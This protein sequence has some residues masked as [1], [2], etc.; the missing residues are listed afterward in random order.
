MQYHYM[1]KDQIHNFYYPMRP[2][3]M[4]DSR[5]FCSLKIR[6]YAIWSWLCCFLCKILIG[7][8][9]GGVITERCYGCGRCSPVCPY[10]KISKF[11]FFFCFVSL[12]YTLNSRSVTLTE[13]KWVLQ[14]CAIWLRYGHI[15]KGRYCHCSTSWTRRRRC[16]RDTY[17][18]KV[19]VS[20]SRIRISIGTSWL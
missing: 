15:H 5:L 20:S 16:S 10:D 13:T 14:N 4:V 12:Y 7:F 9:Q 18:R 2:M 8:V 3:G 19:R 17:Q 11:P 6:I 1:I